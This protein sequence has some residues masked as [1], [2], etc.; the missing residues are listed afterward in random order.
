MEEEFMMRIPR[1]KKQKKRLDEKMKKRILERPD[2]FEE[3]KYIKE[4]LEEDG[5]IEKKDE[6]QKTQKLKM[7]KTLASYKHMK[8]NKFKKIKKKFRRF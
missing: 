1:T 8:K 6:E 2:D 7:Q 3:E 5:I 4:Y